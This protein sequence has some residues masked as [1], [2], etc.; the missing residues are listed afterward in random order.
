MHYYCILFFVN[1]STA[2]KHATGKT[3]IHTHTNKDTYT[4]T[5]WALIFMLFKYK[6][7]KSTKDNAF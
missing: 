2:H 5:H 3:L 4:D 6:V 1:N 7:I